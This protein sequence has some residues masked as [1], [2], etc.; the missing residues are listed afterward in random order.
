MVLLRLLLLYAVDVVVGAVVDT[1]AVVVVDVVVW[2][3]VDLAAVVW[4]ADGE[5]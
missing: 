1:A 4:L 5:P 2:L 3:W